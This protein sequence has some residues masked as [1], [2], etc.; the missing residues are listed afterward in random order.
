MGAR[1]S[2]RSVDISS[3]PKKGELEN[4]AVAGPEEKLEK[5][6][7]G[8]SVAAKVNANGSTTTTSTVTAE[9]QVCILQNSF[10][11]QFI[12][13]FPSAWCAILALCAP[14]YWFQFNWVEGE[15]E[16]KIERRNKDSV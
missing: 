15:R 4:G 10:F 11:F 12:Y 6:E 8:E 5:I 2:K 7:E 16:R 1:Q 3:T 9:Q 14:S 13:S